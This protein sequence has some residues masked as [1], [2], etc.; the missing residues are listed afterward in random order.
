[1]N[2]AGNQIAELDGEVCM[3]LPNLISFDL[4][5]NRLWVISKHVKAIMT[6]KQLMLDQN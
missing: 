3:A 5:N 6:L 4:R 1:L 2:L